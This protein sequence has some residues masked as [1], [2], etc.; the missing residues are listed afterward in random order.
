MIKRIIASIFEKIGYKLFSSQYEIFL[1]DKETVNEYIINNLLKW[2]KYQDS[3]RLQKYGYKSFSQ[4][5]EDGITE[6][7]F[8]RIGELNRI[9]IEFG[10]QNGLESNTHLLLVKGWRGLWIE[11]EEN[12]CL[13][14][15]SYFNHYIKSGAL[16][17]VNEFVT[18]DNINSIISNAGIE[19]EIDFLSIDIDGNDIYVLDVISVVR[20][21]LICIEY[22]ATIRPPLSI[23]LPFQADRK[24]NKTNYFGA[25]LSA[26]NKVCEKKGYSLVGCNLSG[27]NAFFVRNDLLSDHFNENCSPS[28]HYEP[29]RYGL[30]W[31]SG[32]KPG[33]GEWVR[34]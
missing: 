19:G 15:D 32:Q 26:I 24:W 28:N 33:S 2:A 12:Y 10:V 3:K 29:P 21:R 34:I 14:I 1:R 17:V 20:P 8:N 4:N 7:I 9:F 23:A 5:D 16:N 13:E 31:S 27:I 11:A 6:E 30:R 25:S 18:V 22:N